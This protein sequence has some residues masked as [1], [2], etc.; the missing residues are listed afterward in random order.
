MVQFSFL[1]SKLT[2]LIFALIVYVYLLLK[3]Y[4]ENPFSEGG[5]K[6]EI[7]YFVVVSWPHE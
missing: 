2:S 3:I 4:S 6:M 5:E 7:L 1:T